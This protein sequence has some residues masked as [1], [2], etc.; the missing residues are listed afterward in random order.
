MTESSPRALLATNA[1]VRRETSNGSSNQPGRLHSYIGRPETT[2]V[3]ALPSAVPASA[4]PPSVAP[5]A[6]GT[7]SRPTQANAMSLGRS[8]LWAETGGGVV[9]QPASETAA[10]TAA[11]ARSGISQATT[12]T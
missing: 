9:L 11:P 6:A 2:G 7:L 5:P 3:L 10:A 4:V 1:N 8:R 12:P